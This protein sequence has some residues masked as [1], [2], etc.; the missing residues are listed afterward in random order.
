MRNMFRTLAILAS[1]LV[2]ALVVSQATTASTAAVSVA[3]SLLVL[4]IATRI[5]AGT[6]SARTVTV[7]ARARE[8]RES[9]SSMP[10]PAHPDTAG[11]T[12]SRAPSAG[13]LAT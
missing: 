13:V 7:G 3:A 11:R 4:A 12:R 6:A 10:A 2:V 5:V 8:H 9:L 1:V